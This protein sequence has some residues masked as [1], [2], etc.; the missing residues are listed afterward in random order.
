M[1]SNRTCFISLSMASVIVMVA[2]AA[3]SSAFAQAS[4]TPSEASNFEQSGSTAAPAQHTSGGKGLAGPTQDLAHAANP[5]N[6]L[7]SG[8][9]AQARRRQQ[10]KSAGMGGPAAPPG[11][12]GS[13]NYLQSGNPQAK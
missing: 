3:T 7:Q 13:P 8:S 9:H 1:T 6:F 2:L 11:D 10:K 12:E 4:E 5:E